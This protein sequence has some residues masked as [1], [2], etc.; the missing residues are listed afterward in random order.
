MPKRYDRA[1]LAKLNNS[2]NYRNLNSFRLVLT[3][4]LIKIIA[5]CFTMSSKNY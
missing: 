5:E 3:I 4:K 1:C 2:I